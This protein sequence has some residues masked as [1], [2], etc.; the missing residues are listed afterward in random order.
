MGSLF[1][2]YVFKS[3]KNDQLK[4]L[5][6]RLL[7][8]NFLILVIFEILQYEAFNKD[9]SNS[10]LS[11]LLENYILFPMLCL[12]LGFILNLSFEFK[13]LPA[14]SQYIILILFL[15]FLIL[16]IVFGY[17]KFFEDNLIST[18]QAENIKSSLKKILKNIN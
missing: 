7:F 17:F 15:I 13:E 9:N 16:I 14:A 2:V 6:R 4:I 18:T 3:K 1:F 5:V 12:F 11:F 8:T 10:P